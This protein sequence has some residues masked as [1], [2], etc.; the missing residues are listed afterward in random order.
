MSDI[1]H[2]LSQ[3]SQFEQELPDV[4]YSYP[5]VLKVDDLHQATTYRVG[6]HVALRDIE[7]TSQEW[8]MQIRQVFVYGP[9]NNRYY[10]FVDGNYCKAK[11]RRGEIVHDPWT[12]QPMMVPQDYQCLHV[13]P[14]QQLDRK[15]MLYPEPYSSHPRYL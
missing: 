2:W 6:E 13:Q 7:I 1:T 12:G 14:L 9:V 4:A 5:R 11:S 3:D 10:L 8:V 15:F